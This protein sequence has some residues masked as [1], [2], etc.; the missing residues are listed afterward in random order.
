MSSEAR[1]FDIRISEMENRLKKTL[2]KAEQQKAQLR[3]LQTKKANEERKQRT[4]QLI[5][6]GA[7]LASVYG[8][9][10]TKDEVLAVGQ[11]LR[12]QKDAGFF[13]LDG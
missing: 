4:H 1:P 5:I 9:T 6:C 11:F 13:T 8:H 3:D 2:E 10:L 12:T 7:E